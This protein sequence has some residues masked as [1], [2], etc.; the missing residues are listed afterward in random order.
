MNIPR[1]IDDYNNYMG[2]VDIADQYRSYYNT[3]L[4]LQFPWFPILFWLVDTA[5]INSFIMYSD[6]DKL[7][8]HKEF[9]I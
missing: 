8:E 5:L 7:L 2:G 6:L 1:C 3:Q 9:R 4:I